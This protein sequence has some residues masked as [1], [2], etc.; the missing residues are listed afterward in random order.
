MT[1]KITANFSRDRG[2]YNGLAAAWD[3]I[4]QDDGTSWSGYAVVRL[5]CRDVLTESATKKRTPTVEITHIEPVNGEHERVVS[6]IL[7][8]AYQ[9]RTNAG[10]LFDPALRDDEQE[11]TEQDRW[12]AENVTPEPRRHQ[13]LRDVVAS[14]RDRATR[15]WTPSD[16]VPEGM[17]SG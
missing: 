7:R 16:D 15:A 8:D 9:A 12:E 13:G 5:S 2:E 6:D 4:V 10:T 17:I 1:V 3:Q 14:A 11:P